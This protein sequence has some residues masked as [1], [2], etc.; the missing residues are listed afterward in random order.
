LEIDLPE[1]P[2]IPLLAIYPKD[3]PP[4]HSSM[5]STIFILALFVI[6]RTWKQPRCLRAEEWILKIWFIYTVEYYLAIK[7]EDILSFAGKW[8]ELENIILSEVTQTQKY[9]HGMHSLIWERVESKH[10]WE[11]V[12]DL[13]QKWNGEMKGQL[14]EILSYR[15]SLT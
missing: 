7:N 1:D 10:K 12:R 2:E 6:A 15:N 13:E 4:C 14:P 8:M 5:C 11:E 3:V 9:R